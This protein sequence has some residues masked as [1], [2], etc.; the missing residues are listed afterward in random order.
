ML[1]TGPNTTAWS[2]IFHHFFKTPPL[3]SQCSS[4]G[5]LTPPLYCPPAKLQQFPLPLTQKGKPSYLLSRY[6]ARVT[7]YDL[8]KRTSR[9]PL[10]EQ[11]CLKLQ[12]VWPEHGRGQ[13]AR[14]DPHDK[15]DQDSQI[16]EIWFRIHQFDHHR[17][18]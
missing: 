6:R 2:D 8:E 10:H 13:K 11:S 1:Q 9:W 4:H 5:S 3:P 17:E 16:E 14:G 7:P 18:P 12:Y 15:Q